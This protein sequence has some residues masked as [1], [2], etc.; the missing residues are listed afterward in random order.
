MSDSIDDLN[1]YISSQ[2]A[3]QN[4]NNQNLTQARKELF[5][6][7]F[8]SVFNMVVDGLANTGIINKTASSIVKNSAKIIDAFGKFWGWW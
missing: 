3:T 7:A 2:L 4:N 5:E 6:S 1:Q 8:L